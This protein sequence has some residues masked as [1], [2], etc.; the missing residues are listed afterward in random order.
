MVQDINSKT[1]NIIG[2]AMEVHRVLGPGFLESVYQEALSIEFERRVIPYKQECKI[3]INY[4][5]HLLNRFF[6]ADFLCY[7]SVVVELKALSLLLGEHEAQLINYLKA[8]KVKHGLLINFGEQ[9]LKYK[10]FIY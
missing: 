2:A 10:R 1:Y 6:V 9:S 5:D 4:K 8:T 3:E 7:D